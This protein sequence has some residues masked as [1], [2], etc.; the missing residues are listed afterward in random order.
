MSILN[1]RPC[2]AFEIENLIPGKDIVFD[3]VVG[4]LLENDGA[5]PYFLRNL[6]EILIRPVFLRS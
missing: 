6:F 5:D 1:I 2:L 3:P 4:E